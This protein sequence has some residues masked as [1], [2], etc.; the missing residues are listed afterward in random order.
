[1]NNYKRRLI[2][3]LKI[4]VVYGGR[5][6][7]YKPQ[8]LSYLSSLIYAGYV[9]RKIRVIQKQSFLCDRPLV[10][11]GGKY[12]QIHSGRVKDHCRLEA[13][14]ANPTPPRIKIGKHFVLGS[15][16]HIG[17]CST[18]EVGDN[19]L[20]GANCLI[21]D[22]THGFDI[23]EEF[24][25]APT[26]RKLKVKGPIIIGD[27]VFLGDNVVILG[28]ITIGS[29]VTIG[30]STVVTKDIPSDSIAVG[31]PCRIIPKHSN[32]SIYESAAE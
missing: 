27:N 21:T 1:M 9:T 12:I 5:I 14:K 23:E 6:F 32:A 26:E 19:F 7:Y 16:S 11:S 28:N 22:H 18:L 3:K 29:N 31:N 4:L 30:A 24:N 15:F 20:S 13:L 10:I 8:I 25:I 2:D 17:I